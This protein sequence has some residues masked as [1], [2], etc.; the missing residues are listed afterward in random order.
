MKYRYLDINT[1]KRRK[2]FEYFSHMAYPYVSV[3]VN[4]DITEFLSVIQERKLPFFLSFCYCIAKAANGVPE[5]RQRIL[6]NQ[7]IEYTKCRTSHTVSLE[8][9][10]YCYCTLDCDKPFREYLIYAAQEQENSKQERSVEDKQED[11]NELIFI[12]TLPWFSYTALSNPVPIPAD[13]NPR[14]TWGKYSKEEFKTVI[15]VTVQ[16]N[17]ALVDGLHISEFLDALEKELDKVVESERK[18]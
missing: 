16:C 4:I 6:E 17:H 9:G 12:S 14:I 10:T 7:I 5:F 18:M 3:T 8:D 1:Y 13:S 2:H 15:P 11:L